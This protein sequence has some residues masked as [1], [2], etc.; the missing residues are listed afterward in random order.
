MNLT[1]VLVLT[2]QTAQRFVGAVINTVKA[3]MPY[4]IQRGIMERIRL[5]QDV[6]RWRSR[7]KYGD[8]PSKSEYLLYRRTD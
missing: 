3:G 7:V 2:F 6:V 4:M 5:A 1:S 8:I